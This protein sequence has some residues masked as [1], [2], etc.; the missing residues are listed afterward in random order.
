LFVC[1]NLAFTFICIFFHSLD[2]CLNQ[3]YHI[4]ICVDICILLTYCICITVSF[5]L[6]Q[7][8]QYMSIMFNCNSQCFHYSRE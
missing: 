6:Y 1:F 8:V 7:L 4:N 3:F 2:H 5:H